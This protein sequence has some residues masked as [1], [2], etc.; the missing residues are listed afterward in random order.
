MPGALFSYQP[1]FSVF[2]TAFSWVLVSP[3]LILFMF[4]TPIPPMAPL[5]DGSIP[6]PEPRLNHVKYTVDTV[7]RAFT[8]VPLLIDPFQPEEDV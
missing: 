4:Q 6:L 5:R 2:S 3:S 7:A 8:L 1:C